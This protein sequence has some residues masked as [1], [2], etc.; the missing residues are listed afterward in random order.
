M[1]GSLD[2][3]RLS[4]GS[5]YFSTLCFFC[6][7]FES[8]NEKSILLEVDMSK[9][10]EN[11][12]TLTRKEVLEHLAETKSLAHFD[13]RKANLVKIDF[14]GCDLREAN[15][16]YANLKDALFRD[17]DLRGTSLWSANLEG[18]DFTGANLEDADLD[19]SKLRGAI[20]YRANIR[21]A[22]LPTELISR[23]D[24]MASVQ[25]GCKVGVKRV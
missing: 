8:E 3:A 15:L 11:L 13:M 12:V 7:T 6:E 16:S 10:S 14:S 18:A 20:L 5:K 4:G 23:E 17:A 19:Y 21:R 9:N 25:T 24:I 22:T 2:W 1:S